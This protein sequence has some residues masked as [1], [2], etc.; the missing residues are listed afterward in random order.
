MHPIVC[1]RRELSLQQNE[2]NLDI[3]RRI[4]QQYR[5]V[6]TKQHEEG[7]LI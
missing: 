2:I 6:L 3:H 7:V 1:L 5:E 4:D